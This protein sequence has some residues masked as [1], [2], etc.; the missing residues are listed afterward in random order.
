MSTNLLGSVAL[1]LVVWNALVSGQNVQERVYRLTMDHFTFAPSGTLISRERV[2]ADYHKRADGTVRWRNAGTATAPSLTAEFAP[3][4]PLAHV[5]D[6][7]Y[8]VGQGD[9]TKADFF[10]GFPVDAIAE[11]NLIWDTQM[12]ETF[13]SN[14]RRLPADGS[15]YRLPPSDIPLA[16]SG[17]FKNTN[18]ELTAAGTFRSRGTDLAIMRYSALFN[19][20]E[21]ILPGGAKFVGRSDYMG[22]IWVTPKT[23][24]IERGTLYETVVGEVRTPKGNPQVVNVVRRGLFE[25]ISQ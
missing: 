19:P 6:F 7:T 12:F 15:P 25:R 14:F 17:T 1:S 18:I 10:V 16:G 23:G 9:T 3:S 21:L 22:D 5:N 2:S 13:A 11:K 8:R 4:K 24:D 20:L